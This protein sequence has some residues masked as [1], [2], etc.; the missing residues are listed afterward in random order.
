MARLR[1]LSIIPCIAL[2]PIAGGVGVAADEWTHYGLSTWIG[3]CRGGA[4]PYTV[5]LWLQC[6]LMPIALCVML[7]TALLSTLVVALR[8]RTPAASRAVLAGHLGCVVATLLTPLLCPPLLGSAPSVNRML[9]TMA[10][11]E[12]TLTALVAIMLLRALAWRDGR[13]RLQPALL[14]SAT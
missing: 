11:A 9:G 3:L 8:C 13:R 14:T 4:T 7:A 12:L 1:Y 6:N 10:S 2:T 5:A